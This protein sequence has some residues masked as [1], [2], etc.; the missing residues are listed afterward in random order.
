MSVNYNTQV[1]TNRLQQAINAMDAGAGVGVLRLLD[2]AGIILSTLP[3]VKPSAIAAGGVMTFNGL[4]LTDPGAASSGTAV[5]ARIEDSTGT[6]VISGLTVSSAVGADIVLS[7]TN[8]IVA[9]QTVAI[10]AA[11]ITGN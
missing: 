10:T 8:T 9:G 5:A 1:R 4:S 2:A 11:T 7:P 3:L 6:V